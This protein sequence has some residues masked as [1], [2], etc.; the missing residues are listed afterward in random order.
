MNRSVIRRSAILLGLC[1]GLLAATAITP[2]A[3]AGNV[4]WGVSVGGPGFSVTAGQ[5]GFVR[6]PVRPFVRPWVRPAFWAAPRAVVVTSPWLIAPAP[7]VLAP[8]RVV[9]AP[10]PVFYVNRPFAPSPFG[11]ASY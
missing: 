2:M 3:Q 6:A 8:R 4:A 7:V 1:G 11:R 9:L 10:R 5:P